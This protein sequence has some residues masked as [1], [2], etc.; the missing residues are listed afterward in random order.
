MSEIEYEDEPKCPHPTMRAIPC[1]NFQ[2]TECGE[3]IPFEDI[4]DDSVDAE[5]ED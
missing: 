2:C 4:F 3:V 1:G 5:Y